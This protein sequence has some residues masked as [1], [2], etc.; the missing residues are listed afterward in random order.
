MSIIAGR[1]TVVVIDAQS[2]D[3]YNLAHNKSH[4]GASTWEVDSEII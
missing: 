4:F 3:D 2:H 1:T